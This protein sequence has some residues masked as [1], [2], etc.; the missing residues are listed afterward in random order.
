M[1]EKQRLEKIKTFD[2]DFADLVIKYDEYIEREIPYSNEFAYTNITDLKNVLNEDSMHIIFS[3]KELN[4]NNS[5]LVKNTSNDTEYLDETLYYSGKNY[6]QKLNK[7]QIDVKLIEMSAKYERINFVFDI[8]S[9]SSFP[10]W[11]TKMHRKIVRVLEEINNL[12]EE[13]ITE[14]KITEIIH[15]N[16]LEEVRN[17]NQ[18]D[19]DLIIKHVI[20]FAKNKTASVLFL[21]EKL[22]SREKFLIGE[23][24]KLVYA[25]GLEPSKRNEYIY[26]T[27]YKDMNEMF[28]KFG[29]CNFKENKCLS[30]RHKSSSNKYPVPK[31]DGCCFKVFNKC[32]YN[33][34]DGTCKIECLACKI[35]TC[36]YLTNLG[37]GLR[38]SE[39]IL[40]RAF[41]NQKQKRLLIYKFYKPKE[42]FIKR[43]S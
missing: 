4:L 20:E 32:N 24:R 29:F 23:L 13:D 2:N 6:E 10:I 43:M 39:L 8:E 41:M 42:F 33:N 11:E 26:D 14:E 40:I 16:E 12:T 38:I 37:V 1:L 17:E 21:S 5:Y 35:F 7:Y 31:T 28:S 18:Y 25:A 22:G 9:I 19:I 15:K 36:P 3:N 34:K 30:Q 27:T